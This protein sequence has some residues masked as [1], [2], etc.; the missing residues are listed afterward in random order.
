MLNILFCGTVFAAL[1]F[2]IIIPIL[3]VNAAMTIIFRHSIRIHIIIVDNNSN[4]H[5]KKSFLSDFDDA[6]VRN[7]SRM[8]TSFKNNVNYFF[9]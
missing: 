8:I 9:S 6:K 1:F 7:I 3:Y 4:N 5:Q 2:P